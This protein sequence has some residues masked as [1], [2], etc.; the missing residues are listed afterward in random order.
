MIGIDTNILVRYI[1]QD[2]EIQSRQATELIESAAGVYASIFINNIVLCELVWVLER[3]YKY[4]KQQVI[5]VLKAVL[6]SV[7]F[8]FEDHKILWTSVL[9]LEKSN[10][11]FSDI[12]ISKINNINNCTTS[13]T[14]DTN[15][16]SLACFTHLS[17][18]VKS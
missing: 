15:A 4:S 18:K 10:A 17:E 5:E 13:Y 9:D 14:F 6:T 8:C 16:S 11:D 1:T 12:L 3:G 7:E 2:D